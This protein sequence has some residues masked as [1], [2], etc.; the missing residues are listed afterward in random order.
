MVSVMAEQKCPFRVR[1]HREPSRIFGCLCI[2]FPGTGNWGI[3]ERSSEV[4]KHGID[5][6]P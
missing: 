2:C 3:A 6:G 5:P 1:K 4:P